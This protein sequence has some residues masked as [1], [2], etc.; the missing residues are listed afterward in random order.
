[1]K[2]ERYW[3]VLGT[4]LKDTAKAPPDPR[5][6]ARRVV[7]RLPQTKQLRRHWW[8]PSP[9]H[10]P[11]APAAVDP[12]SRPSPIP[13][14][15]GPTPTVIGRTQTMFSPVKAI[16][17]GALVFAIGG[18]FLI[19]Q[20]FGQQG[21]VPGAETDAGV[22]EPVPFSVSFI[23]TDENVREAEDVTEGGL[24]R[25]IG[26]CHAMEIVDPSDP[27]IAGELTWCSDEHVYGE[28]RDMSPVVWTDTWRI[29]N[30]DGAWQG[31]HN[32]FLWNDPSSGRLDL[33]EELPTL[34]G[35]GAY[36]GL[37]A[38]MTLMKITGGNTWDVRGV[39]FEGPLPADP[40]PPS[41]E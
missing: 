4:W 25:S 32:G 2:D 36:D 39:I 19:A 38:P 30:D 5:Q 21:S 3:P 6:T 26:S 8:F 1:M 29:V 10:I 13:A 20:P 16:T 14:V 23:W 9:R 22:A 24:T 28:N 37:Y 17:A 40:I 18:A 33:G 34:V 15:N 11:R 41:A 27:R 12:T 7:D 35:E 31:S